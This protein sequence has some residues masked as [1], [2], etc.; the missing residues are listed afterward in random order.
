MGYARLAVDEARELAFAAALELDALR[1]R[2]LTLL[3]RQPESE[4]GRRL[5][6]V[7]RRPGSLWEAVQDLRRLAAK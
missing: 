4:R 6:A 3:E 7:C 2:I 1:K 5:E